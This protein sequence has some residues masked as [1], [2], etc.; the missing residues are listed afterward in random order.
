[1]YALQQTPIDGGA[2]RG[3]GEGRWAGMGVIL[4]S[5]KRQLIFLVH[6]IVH[7]TKSSD[8][9]ANMVGVSTPNAQTPSM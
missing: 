8:D 9:M 1:M 4:G 7:Y 6:D 5:I 2:A 3:G